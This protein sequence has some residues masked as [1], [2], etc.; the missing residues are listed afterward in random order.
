MSFKNDLLQNGVTEQ[1]A[2]YVTQGFLELLSGQMTLA[3][4]D[5]DLAVSLFKAGR[6]DEL[7][8]ALQAM[9]R[10]LA[11]A[12]FSYRTA[13]LLIEKDGDDSQIRLL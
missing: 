10:R 2:A 12:V 13:S 9:G 6:A 7:N 5:A 8:A 11:E 1:K 4:E 3:S